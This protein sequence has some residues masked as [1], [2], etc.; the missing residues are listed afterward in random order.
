MQSAD[1][2][3]PDGLYCL[4]RL[5]VYGL[6]VERDLARG[7]VFIKSSRMETFM[8]GD[9][10]FGSLQGRLQNAETPSID[11]RLNRASAP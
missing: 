3:N 8:A 7:T 2:Q 6:G 5:Y 10:L 11:V 9:L 1:Q 4:G